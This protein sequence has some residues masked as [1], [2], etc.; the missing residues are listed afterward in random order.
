MTLRTRLVLALFLLAVVPLSGATVLAYVSSERAFRKAVAAEASVLAEEIGQRMADVGQELWRRLDRFQRRETQSEA[1]AQARQQ[2]LAAAQQEQ[3][4]E[5]V[6]GVLGETP[7]RRGE[8]PFALDEQ[9]QVLTADPAD[10]RA[11]QAIGLRELGGGTDRATVRGDYLVVVKSGSGAGLALGIARPVGEAFRDIRRTAVFNLAVGLGLVGLALLGILPLSRRMTQDLSALEAGAARLAGGDLGSRVEVASRDEIGRLAEAFNRMGGELQAH[12]ERLLAE[13]RLRKELE[14][15]RRIQTELLPRQPL[16]LPHGLVEGRSQPAREVGGDF[17]DYFLLPRGDVAVLVGDVS[18]KGIAAALLMANVQATLRG[19]L[20]AAA[21]LAALATR[22]DGELHAQTPP[23]SY[24]T[25]F[26]SVLEARDPVLRYVNA[27][28]NPP[29]V[30]DGNGGS[31][32]LLPSTGRPIGLLPGGGYEERSVALRGGE[33]LVLYTDGV[34]DLENEAEEPL[35]LERFAAL[36]DEEH[37]RGLSGL[38]ER[39][40]TRLAAWRGRA[41][42]P[43]DATIVLLEVGPGGA[44]TSRP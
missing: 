18:G 11:L 43:D 14:M 15:C 26:A 9:G 1:F 25:L 28:H 40:E 44:P 23:E 27:G 24:L 19:A 2:A 6:R 3:Y 17:F 38:L 33:T 13:E 32:A 21:D 12:Q 4:K 37:R 30:L 8:I 20:P 36:L 5:V 31:P 42:P 10:E 39:V 41:E 16:A 34:V 22:L 29:L 7:R 35:G